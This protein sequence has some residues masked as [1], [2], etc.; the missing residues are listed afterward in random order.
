MK[1]L[2]VCH[3]VFICSACIVEDGKVLFAIPEERLDRIKLSRVFPVKAI[4]ECFRQTGLSMK[5]IDEIAVSWNPAIDA[6]T[7]PSGFVTGRRWRGEHLHSIPARF[8]QMGRH[9]ASELVTLHDLWQG[10]APITYVDHYHSHF[11]NAFFLSPYEEAA[12]A[13]LDGRGE[14]HTGLIGTA[15]GVNLEVLE[16]IDYPHSLGLL[17]GAVTQFLG[18]TPDSDEW[19]VMALASY[20]NPD[21]EYLAPMQKLIHV[22]H[23]GRFTV[24]LE[25]FSYFNS[26][27]PLMFSPRFVEVFGQPRG[28]NEEITSR[29]EKIGAALQYVF[30]EVAVQVLTNLYHRTK[31]KKLVATG[32]CFMN[33]VFNGKITSRTPFEECYI[34]SCPDD[35]GT[36]MGAALY[37]CAQRTG[38]R[39]A[40]QTYHSYWGPGYSDEYCRSVVEKLKLPNAQVLEDPSEAAANDLVGGRL[41]GWLQEKSEFGQRA[42]GHRS[43]LADPRHKETKDIINAAVKYRESFRPFAPAILDDAVTDYFDCPAGTEVPFMEKVFPFRKERRA[44]VPA[45]VHV[46]GTGRLQ[47]VNENNGLR[48]QRVIQSFREKTGIPIIL[49]TS[50]NLNG[51]PIV[52]SPEDAV[53]TFYSCGLDVLYLGNIR[54]SK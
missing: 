47:T 12:V 16:K 21:N 5:D 7:S 32:G 48:F 44:E 2:G 15:R 52:C 22:D 3:D 29:H 46:D 41:V 26:W 9:S 50:F 10:A 23:S 8:L 27:D 40:D 39:A 14:R 53:R 13:A 30:E 36:S 34:T 20:A 19:K 28:R 49:N 25:Y 4:Q 33:S 37:V 43:I 45:V 51:E 24:A 54:I 31:L 17:Y 18:F 1:V 11:G 42:L 38:K 6:E 35:S